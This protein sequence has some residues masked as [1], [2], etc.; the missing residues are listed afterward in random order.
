M[1]THL[2]VYDVGTSSLR[3]DGSRVFVH[4]ADVKGRYTTLRKSLFTV[5]I[6]FFFGL[7]WIQMGGHPALFIDIAKRQFYVLGHTFNAQDFWLVFFLLTGVGFLL[8]VITAL[9]GRL[10]CGYA[11]P[12]TVFLE[13]VFRRLE[14]VI[15]GPRNTRIRRNLGP[16]TLDKWARKLVKHALFVAISLLIAHAF[17]S[18][19]VSAPALLQMMLKSPWRHPQ[20][21]AWTMAL[22]TVWYVNF[23]WFREQ[24]C[25]IVCPYGRL[26][27]VLTDAE[28]TIIGYDKARGEP[29]GKVGTSTGDCVDCQRCVVVCPTAIDIREGL[30]LDCVGC[31]ACIDACDEVMDR[32]GRPRGLIRYDST[33]G[34]AGR[35]RRKIRPRLVLYAMLGTFGLLAFSLAIRQR[36]P[37]EATLLRM[38][39][40]PYLVIDGKIRNA[41]EVHLINKRSHLTTLSLQANPPNGVSLSLG[42]TQVKL[43]SL[44]SRRVPLVVESSGAPIT[45][46][47]LTL[48]VSDLSATGE[49]YRTE[50]SVPL[51]GPGS[52]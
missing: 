49:M 38:S 29:R 45:G 41:F 8:I 20:A 3:S 24:T 23:A 44:A 1:S 5:L 15:E 16:W 14:R 31:A 26:Q 13:G 39:G 52:R 50:I 40:A 33:V 25:L 32:L 28:T 27:S 22:A 48:T 2:H 11:C 43:Q 18:Y 12:Q 19:F 51:L 30:Q 37:F 7:P 35:L 42:T 10:F 36:P 46:T 47:T 17:I 4:P 34:L 9:W 6:G 21:F